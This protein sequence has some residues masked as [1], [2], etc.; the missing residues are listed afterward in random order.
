MRRAAGRA[1]FDCV[2]VGPRLDLDDGGHV[3]PVQT[4]LF[5]LMMLVS[6]LFAGQVLTQAGTFAALP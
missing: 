2:G 1:D 6:L 3:D 4:K 5:L